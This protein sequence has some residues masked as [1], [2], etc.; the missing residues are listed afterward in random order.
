MNFDAL[1]EHKSHMLGE[2]LAIGRLCSLGYHNIASERVCQCIRFTD[3]LNTALRWYGVTVRRPY[4]VPGPNSLWYIGEH[5]VRGEGAWGAE[6]PPPP[7]LL[8]I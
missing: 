2:T 7:G 5:W 6:A 4:S 3:P 8:T 1:W